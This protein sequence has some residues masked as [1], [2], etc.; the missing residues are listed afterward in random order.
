MEKSA[1]KA[2]LDRVELRKELEE[3]EGRSEGNAQKSA[4]VPRAKPFLALL[5]LHPE[6]AI[7]A[8]RVLGVK[9]IGW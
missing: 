2:E 6:C 1:K 4:Q 5:R 7:K 3:L 9:A 8:R